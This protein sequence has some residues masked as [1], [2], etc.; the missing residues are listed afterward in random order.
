MRNFTVYLLWRSLKEIRNCTFDLQVMEKRSDSIFFFHS[1]GLSKSQ[2]SN[3]CRLGQYELINNEK[4]SILN[5][6]SDH[7]KETESFKAQLK[8][9]LRSLFFPVNQN[10]NKGVLEEPKMCYW[11]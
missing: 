9:E 2:T 6:N 4:L 3:K 10:P 1:Q 11:C 5:C 7:E 8:T